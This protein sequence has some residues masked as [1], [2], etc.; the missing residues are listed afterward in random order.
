M[1]FTNAVPREF[2]NRC[3]P[4]Y[5][6]F[7][8]EARDRSIETPA[9][10]VQV[11]AVV[12]GGAGIQVFELHDGRAFRALVYLHHSLPTDGVEIL[13][14]A[15]FYRKLTCNNNVFKYAIVLQKYCCVNVYV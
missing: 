6:T 15:K 14:P 13:V 7:D 3:T 9:R 4:K 12:P 2:S 8:T 1:Y 11:S 10:V 5:D